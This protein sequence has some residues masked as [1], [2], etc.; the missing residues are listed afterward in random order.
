MTIERIEFVLDENLELIIQLEISSR[1][2][3]KP[4]TRLIISFKGID[5]KILDSEPFLLKLKTN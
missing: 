5:F 2:L 4:G 1:I 3:I